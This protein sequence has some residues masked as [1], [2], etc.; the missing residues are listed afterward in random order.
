MNALSVRRLSLL[1]E[2]DGGGDHFGE[3][4]VARDI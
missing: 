3:F 2:G 4:P 1:E